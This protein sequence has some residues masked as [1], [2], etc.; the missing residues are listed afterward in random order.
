M[1]VGE[2]MGMVLKGLHKTLGNQPIRQQV[3]GLEA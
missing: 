1:G 3:A 2:Y